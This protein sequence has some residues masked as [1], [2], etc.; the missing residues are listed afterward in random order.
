[1]MANIPQKYRFQIIL[2]ARKLSSTVQRA[3]LE[4]VATGSCRVSTKYPSE[5]YIHPNHYRAV[6]W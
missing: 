6:H 3:R 1:M 4:Y 2:R 5:K